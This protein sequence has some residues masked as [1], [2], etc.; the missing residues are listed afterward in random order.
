VIIFFLG[1][2]KN[3]KE[4]KTHHKTKPKKKKLQKMHPPLAFSPSLFGNLLML[5]LLS[6]SS[7][8]SFVPKSGCFHMSYRAPKIKKLDV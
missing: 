3:I 7:S 2:D 1:L 6:S 5:V 8:S 4:K